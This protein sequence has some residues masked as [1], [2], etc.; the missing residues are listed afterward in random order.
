MLMTSLNLQLRIIAKGVCKYYISTLWGWGGLE[1]KCLYCLCKGSKF[2]F[3]WKWL[4]SLWK[5]LNSLVKGHIWENKSYTSLNYLIYWTREWNFVF[6]KLEFDTIYYAYL[7]ESPFKYY[8]SILGGW[9]LRL[10]LFC[11]FRGGPEFGKKL[12]I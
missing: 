3:T 6:R 11:L 4:L 12:L 5:S 10:C 1:T 7:N 9:G 2:L 8:I